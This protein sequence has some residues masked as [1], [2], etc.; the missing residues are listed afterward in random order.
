MKNEEMQS[1][2]KNIEQIEQIV[3]NLKTDIEKYV[4]K[5]QKKDKKIGEL[6]QEIRD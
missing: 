5:N 6:E 3:L 1:R 2:E 4:I